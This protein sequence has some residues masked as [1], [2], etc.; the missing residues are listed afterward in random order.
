[1]YNFIDPGNRLDCCDR[2]SRDYHQV[3]EEMFQKFLDQSVFRMGLAV[4]YLWIS[5]GLAGGNWK[6]TAL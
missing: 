5:C 4:D 2:S 6:N 3:R 1:M